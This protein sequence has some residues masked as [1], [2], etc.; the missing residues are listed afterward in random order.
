ML[1]QFVGIK[2]FHPRSFTHRSS[3]LVAAVGPAMAVAGKPVNN[4]DTAS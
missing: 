3:S 4:F 2:G 1:F